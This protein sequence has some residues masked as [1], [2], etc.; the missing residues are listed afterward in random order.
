MTSRRQ[1]LVTAPLLSAVAAL[2][3]C[4]KQ[5]TVSAETTNSL[6]VILIDVSASV[7]DDERSFYRDYLQKYVVRTIRPGDRVI[8]VRVG[9]APGA[10]RRIVDTSLPRASYDAPGLLRGSSVKEAVLDCQNRFQRFRDAKKALVN[11]LL[12]GFGEKAV[13]QHT[14]LI[15]TLNL[16]AVQYL[17]SV[18]GPKS[19][20]IFS[21]MFE[22]E[23][24]AGFDFEHHPPTKATLDAALRR[25]AESLASVRVTVIGANGG[26][27]DSDD[28]FRANRAFWL[29]FFKALGADAREQR[30]GHDPVYPDV[31]PLDDSAAPCGG[32]N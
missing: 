4:G 27:S 26:S 32:D 15:Q 9:D 31:A 8:A 24:G 2:A 16:V 1:F 17:A 6:L 21:D 13:A 23:V 30:Y 3:G 25:G 29:G 14:Y 11:T 18:T 20:V 19:L 10:M 7:D 28:A 22:S 5:Q 12:A